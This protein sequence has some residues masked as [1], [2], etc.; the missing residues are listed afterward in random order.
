[1]N[2]TAGFFDA[3][4]YMTLQLLPFLK[5]DDTGADC[6]SNLSFII[7]IPEFFSSS[8]STQTPVFTLHRK[9]KEHYIP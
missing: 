3:S 4:G 6:L 1:L 5:A 8:L 2:I 9:D 7:R